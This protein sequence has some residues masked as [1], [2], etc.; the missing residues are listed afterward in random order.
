M[1]DCIFCKI[2]AGEIPSEKVFENDKIVAFKDINPAAP[3]H[4]LV[5]PKEHIDGADMLDE[6]NVDIVKDIFLTIR[7]ITEEYH[8]DTG[9][10][11]ITNVKE[12]GGQTVR[13]LHFHVIG[14]KKLGE[15]MC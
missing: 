2:A 8:L 13:H 10:R 11:V 5:V 15:K 14:G 6:E 7:R 1:S 9:Y 12:D 4:V 3:F